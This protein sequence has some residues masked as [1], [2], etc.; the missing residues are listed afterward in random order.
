MGVLEN[1]SNVYLKIFSSLAGV[2][3]EGFSIGSYYF[4]VRKHVLTLKGLKGKEIHCTHQDGLLLIAFMKSVDRFL[5]HKDI[6]EVCSW[7][8]EACGLNERRRTAISQLRKLFV[9]CSVEIISVRNRGGYQLVII[10]DEK[11]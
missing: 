6:A 9:D 4:S 7:P 11:K 1:L 3:D 8:L 10:E 2:P 5:S